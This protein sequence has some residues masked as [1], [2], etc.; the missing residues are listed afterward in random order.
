MA[1]PDNQPQTQQPSSPSFQLSA[2]L[3]P[4]ELPP[5]HYYPSQG[6][7]LIWWFP[8]FFVPPLGMWINA[9][10]QTGGAEQCSH[11]MMTAST[12]VMW[13]GFPLLWGTLHLFFGCK[14]RHRATMMAEGRITARWLHL[15]GVIAAIAIASYALNRKPRLLSEKLKNHMRVCCSVRS[16]AVPL[17]LRELAATRVL[18]L[19]V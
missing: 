17:P 18:R 12:V 5:A 11:P 3:A 14:S 4:G 1:S 9:I 15:G 19:L 6:W 13:V 7:V 10:V 16:R 8:W 2:P